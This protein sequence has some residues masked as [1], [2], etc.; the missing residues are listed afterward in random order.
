[1]DTNFVC[2]FT[3]PGQQYEDLKK[4]KEDLVEECAREK[5]AHKAYKKECAALKAEY[6]IIRLKVLFSMKSSLCI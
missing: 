6:N 4:A 1:M 3:L 2:L 5:N